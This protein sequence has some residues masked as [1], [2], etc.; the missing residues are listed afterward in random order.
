MFLYWGAVWCPP[1]NQLK[2][3][4]FNR[5]DFIDRSKSF[6]AV[7]IDGDLP[8]AQKMATDIQRIVRGIGARHDRTA[9]GMEAP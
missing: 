9:T 3:T 4:L 1:C 5:A 6:V 7:N 8:G 2:A